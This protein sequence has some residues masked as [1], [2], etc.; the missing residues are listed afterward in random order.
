MKH[1]YVVRHCK[2][3]GQEPAAPLTAAGVLQAVE[4][5]EF[6]ADKQIEYIV[7]S[8]FERACRTIAPLADQLGVAVVLDDRL[9]ERVLSGTNH[10]NWR[11]MLRKTYD[12]LDL[13]YE[14]GETGSAAM[15]RVTS[16]VMEIL[17][18]R[19]NNAVIIS[20]GNLISL[21]LK[22]YDHRVGFEEWEAMSNPDVYHL[23]LSVDRPGVIQRIWKSDS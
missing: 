8:P 21:L 5:A 22:H 12:D 20:H 10:P 14:G 3:A 16:V 2:A 17:H 7:S 18:S 13:C 6:L 11:D 1:V 23:S 4:L 9:T 15:N 19:Y